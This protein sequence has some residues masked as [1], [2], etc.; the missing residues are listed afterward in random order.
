MKTFVPFK[1]MLLKIA[2]LIAVIF[3]AVAG[4]SQTISELVFQNPT[5]ISGTAGQDGAQY[6]FSNVATG[7]DAVIQIKGRTS[8]AV[9][10]TAIDTTGTG[11]SKAWQPVLKYNG[12]APSHSSWSMDF[13]IN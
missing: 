9:I 6:K 2:L 4:Y 12:T 5:L 7:I 10:L 3:S 13:R 1:K 11:Y 8:N